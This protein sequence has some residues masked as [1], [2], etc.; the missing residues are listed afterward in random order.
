[1]HEHVSQFLTHLG[2]LVDRETY[3]VG[4]FSLSL[5]GT[6]FTW[7]ATLPPNSIVWGL[8]LRRRSSRQKH[9]WQNNTEARRSHLQPWFSPSRRRPRVEAIMQ[10]AEA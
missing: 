5:T 9:L 3:C 6:A 10:N 2:E 4:L 1:M 7:Y 8:L